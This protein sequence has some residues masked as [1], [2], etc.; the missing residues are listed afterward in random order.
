MNTASSPTI[1][2]RAR[3]MT[4]FVPLVAA[5]GAPLAPRLA[6]EGLA[7]DALDCLEKTVPLAKMVRLI[8][9]A[10]VEL[11]APDFG[12]RMSQ[13]QDIGVLG[14][15]EL[16]AM[17]SATAG[18]AIEAISA[19]MHY[20][21][22]GLHVSLEP[23]PERPGYSQVQIRVADDGSRPMGQVVELC[24][25]VAQ[26]FLRSVT[27]DAGADWLVR[28]RHRAVLTA[29][30]YAAYFPCPVLNGQ[31]ADTLSLPTRLLEV[32]ISPSDSAMQ[33]AAQRYVNNLVRRFPLD[34][35][36]QVEALVERQLAAGGG[37]LVRIS[38][39]LGLHER[40]LQ[41]RLKEQGSYFED[42][43]DRVRRRR[44][45]EYLPHAVIPLAQVAALLG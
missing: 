12:L 31:T 8:A 37:N 14:P 43:V 36:H 11:D 41:R 27:Q 42:I 24:F 9:D 5:L 23:D 34:I 6:R 26:Q 4:G 30:Q 20:H 1:L 10:A 19:N 18:E 28:F 38:H 16:V 32:P 44:A 22:P 39:Q 2:I 17:H 45:E 3:S 13:Y 33:V 35:T 7:A 40:T 15:V 29:A 25:G 21:S